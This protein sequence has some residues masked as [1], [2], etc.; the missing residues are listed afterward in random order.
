MST[1]VKVYKHSMEGAPQLSNSWGV[2]TDLLDAVLVNGFNLKTITGISRVGSVATAAIGAGMVTEVDQVLLIAGS[3]Q[4]EYNG[5]FRVLSSTSNSFTFTVT[6]SPVTPATG[7]MS[8]KVAPLGWTAPFTGT[9]K[10][11]YR[12][13]TGLRHYLRVDNSLDPANTTTYAKKGKVTICESMT[14]IDTIVGAQAPYSAGNPNLNHVAT[15]SGTA[16]VDGWYKWYYARGEADNADQIAPAAGNRQWTIIGDDRGFYFFTEHNGIYGKAAYAFTEFESF[17]QGDAYNTYIAATEFNYNASQTPSQAYPVGFYNSP[18]FGNMF[19]ANYAQTYGYAGKQILRSHLQVG[20]PTSAAFVA[21]TAYSGWNTNIPWPNGPDMSLLL[22]PP[23]LIQAF[24]GGVR[25]KLPGLMWVLN[26]QPLSDLQVV[27]NVA[28]YEGRKFM[29]IQL[30][31]SITATAQGAVC[32][33]AFDITGPW[34]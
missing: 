1:T 22:Q 20:A 15:G 32:R 19:A 8:V 10:R 30:P 12:A 5:E 13:A 24:D 18:E 26:N 34:R 16:V 9:N 11:A 27:N 3:D 29:I 6:G 33:M 28:G 23:L 25:G 2:L 17:R 7:T 4:P 21:S 31:M 14:D